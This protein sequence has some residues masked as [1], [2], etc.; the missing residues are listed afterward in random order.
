MGTTY[1]VTYDFTADSVAVAD[2]VDTNFNDLLAAINALDAGNLASGT[3][4]LARISGLTSTQMAA[5]FFKDEDAMASDSATAVASQ[6]SIKAYIATQVLE[7]GDSTVQDDDS[8]TMLKAH[9]Y[10]ANQDGFVVVQH[11]IDGAMDVI[12]YIDTDTNPA[13]GGTVA[14]RL[15]TVTYVS[16]ND[17]HTMTFPVASGKYFEITSA[18]GTQVI[19]WYPIG[20][21]VKCT[22]QD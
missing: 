13:S 15:K 18:N 20:T 22:D 19:R 7:F 5:A 12:G 10:L 1:T 21:L 8:A 2:Q 16:P 3:V 14:G 9:A 6:Q 17:V 4:A 11:T